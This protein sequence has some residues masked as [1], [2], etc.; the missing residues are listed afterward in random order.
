MC[1]ADI[2]SSDIV[3]DEGDE[4]LVAVRISGAEADST[5]SLSLLDGTALVTDDYDAVFSYSFDGVNWIKYDSNNPISINEGSNKFIVKVTTSED[6]TYEVDESFALIAKL[7]SGE[8]SSADIYIKEDDAHK[9]VNIGALHSEYYGVNSQICSL[10]QFKAI[11]ENSEPDAIFNS[12]SVSYGIG[13]GTVSNGSHLQDFLG[14]DA[15]SLSIDPGNTSDGGIHISGQVYLVEGTYNFKVLADDGYGI[16]IDGQ[17]VAS[18]EN[19]QA[20]TIYEH[21]SFTITESGYHDVDM[22]W[23]DQGGAYVFKPELSSDGGE[24]YEVFSS[25]NY[26]F[27]IEST[28][29]DENDEGRVDIIGTDS[30]DIINI[31][32]GENIIDAREGEDTLVLQEDVDLNFANI[33]GIETIDFNG[34]GSNVD[35][36]SLD[37]VLELTDSDNTLTLHGTESDRI[38]SINT[39]GWTKDETSHTDGCNEYIY[40][41]DISGDSVILKVDENI[42]SSGL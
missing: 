26:T 15:S 25:E 39:D 11:V 36:L 29:S 34:H 38:N 14:D 30:D 20:P 10:T 22:F 1:D 17:D 32:I 27:G 37:D 3:V 8:N 4:A 33:S 18:Y 9:I 42:D 2:H 7:N 24:T 12:T 35:N 5:I 16:F 40:T 21:D 31:G 23:W 28:E 6:S 19:N 41:N 13:Y